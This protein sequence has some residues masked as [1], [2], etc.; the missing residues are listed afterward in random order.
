MSHNKLKRKAHPPNPVGRP[1]QYEKRFTKM[2]YRFSLLGATKA[3][4]ADAFGVVESTIYDW[5]KHIPE[6]AD[7]IKQGGMEADS[8]V[9]KALY[10][11]ALGYSHKE[12]DIKC[13]LGKIIKTDTIKQYAPDTTAAFIWLKN[14][15]ALGEEFNN[16][17]P[18]PRAAL[19]WRDK[20]ET[21]LSGPGGIPLNQ[22]NND[23]RA[24]ATRVAL[25]RQLEDQ[26]EER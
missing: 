20:Q 8:K 25:L 5:Q 15:R 24:R 1:N 9:A 10:E 3:E 6:F 21:E 7:A 18:N 13:Y 22:P 14:R 12:T 11:R 19:K 2:A 23:E 16:T 17:S 26:G 4:M